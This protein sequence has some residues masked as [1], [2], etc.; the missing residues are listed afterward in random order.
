MVEMT[1]SMQTMLVTTFF[2]PLKAQT[3]VTKL[4][5][6]G[7]LTLF[8]KLT[9]KRGKYAELLASENVTKTKARKK[10]VTL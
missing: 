2:S 5:G 9:E 1:I 6:S 7:C 10:V 8:A 4:S 3:A